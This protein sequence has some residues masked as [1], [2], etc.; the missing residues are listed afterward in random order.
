MKDGHP[1][2][3]TGATMEDGTV[4]RADRHGH[5][6]VGDARHAAQMV[7]NP[8]APGHVVEA[9]FHGA[10]VQGVTCGGCGFSGFRWQ[11]SA[12]CPRCGSNNWET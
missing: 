8:L 10:G 1:T 7:S 3:C 6:E 11:A 2:G 12:P 4:Y 9:K 5:M